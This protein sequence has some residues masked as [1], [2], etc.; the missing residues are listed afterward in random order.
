[1][2]TLGLIDDLLRSLRLTGHLEHGDDELEHPAWS[3]LPSDGPATL[4]DLMPGTAGRV[5]DP[6]HGYIAFTGIERTLFDHPVAQRLRAISQSAAAHLVFPEMRVSRFA[7]SLGAMHLASRFFAAILRN[8]EGSE[9]EQIVA[10]CRELVAAHSGLGLGG[11]EQVIVNEPALVAAPELG[12][13][14]AA[15][16]FVEQGLRLASLAHDLGHLPFS[17]DFETALDARLRADPALRERLA[18]LYAAGVR[19]DKIHERVGYALAATVQQR[20]FNAELVGTPS[21][22]AAEVSLLVAR[23]ILDAP[24]APELED[25]ATRAV[26]SWLHSL[27]DGQIDVDR[28]DYVLRDVRAYGLSAAVYDLD[29]LVDSLV[30]VRKGDGQAIVTAILPSGVSAAESFFVARFRMYAWAIFHHKIQ[31]AAAG[32]RLAIE[33]VLTAGGAEIDAFMNTI[34]AIAAGRA[35]DTTLLAFADCDDVWFTGL[36]RAR[37]RSGV[38]ADIEPWSALFLR[39]RPGPVSLWKRPSDFPVDDRAGWNRRLPTRDDPELRARWDAIVG[40]FRSEGLIVHRLPFAPWDADPDGESSLRVALADTTKPLTRLSPL[41]RALKPAWDDE[42][43]V[44]IYA[45]QPGLADR[46]TTLQRLEPA[47]RPTE[48]TP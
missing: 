1:M 30:P 38:P 9:R 47:L 15:V 45:A 25:D 39:R 5:R 23:D 18:P 48:E 24:A 20:V 43:Q 10:A 28:A 2:D 8:A 14:R 35:T 29:R 41:V 33:D 13:D 7:H 19:G 46:L 17:H 3:R 21:A 44:H 22:K 27:V 34:T 31:Q 6:V 36:M 12:R 11:A 40:E 4:P 32:M 26:L 42:L 37:L 16:L